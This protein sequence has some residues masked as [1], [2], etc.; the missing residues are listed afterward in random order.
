LP[1]SSEAKRLLSLRVYL[2]ENDYVFHTR[3]R[4]GHIGDPRAT[5]ERVSNVACITISCHD[6]RRTF[7]GIGYS[8]CDIALDKIERLTNHVAQSVTERHYLENQRLQKLLPQ[9]QKITDWIVE[10]ACGVDQKAAQ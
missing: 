6:L 10:Q 2:R 7:S 4:T 8:H 9:V 1:L 3:S 5:V